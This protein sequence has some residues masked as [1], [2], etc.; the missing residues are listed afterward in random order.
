MTLLPT[1]LGDDAPLS[2]EAGISV[3]NPPKPGNL[4]LTDVLQ[5]TLDNQGSVLRSHPRP[6]R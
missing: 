3:A 4:Q 1:N 2:I 6:T 5:V